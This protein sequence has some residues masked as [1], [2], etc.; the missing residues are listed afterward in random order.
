MSDEKNP[1]RDEPM[2]AG[3]PPE[4]ESTD[5]AN[6]MVSLLVINEMMVPTHAWLDR[7]YQYFVEKGYQPEHARAMSAVSYLTTSSARTER[8]TRSFSAD[9]TVVMTLPPRALIIW[10]SSSPTPPA[11]A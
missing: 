7:E 10:V 2:P 6:V 4:P 5:V 1:A 11:P 9:D 8:D 3:Q